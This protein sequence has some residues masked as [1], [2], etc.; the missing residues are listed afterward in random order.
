MILRIPRIELCNRLKPA[1]MLDANLLRLLR[2]HPEHTLRARRGREAAT[3]GVHPLATVGAIEAVEYGARVELDEGGRERGGDEGEPGV[4]GGEEVIAIGGVDVQQRGEDGG[5]TA[6]G[7]EHGVYLA[8][9]VLAVEVVFAGGVEVHYVQ[10]G[11]S[12]AAAAGRVAGEELVAV[13]C[14]LLLRLY[15]HGLALVL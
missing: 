3:I 10:E 9:K 7:C 15:A 8:D 2:D 5:L 14:V 13:L 1:V 11:P 4:Q 12:S 6:G